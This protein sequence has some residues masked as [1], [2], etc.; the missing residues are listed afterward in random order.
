MFKS[1]PLF[2]LIALALGLSAC[3]QKKETASIPGLIESKLI[4]NRPVN[5]DH[6]I[7][8]VKLKNPALLSSA[9]KNA[10]GVMEVEGRRADGAYKFTVTRQGDVWVLTNTER[11]EPAP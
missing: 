5:W 6:F 1:I 2:V 11:T 10:E 4:S 8:I 7:A 3:A 9:K